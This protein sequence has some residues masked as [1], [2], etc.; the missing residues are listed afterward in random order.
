MINISI[1]TIC[2]DNS[3]DLIRTL[4]SLVGQTIPPYEIII[5]DS[6]FEP[7]TTRVLRGRV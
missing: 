4:S 2:K 6:S 7:L 3:A 5:I 1:I